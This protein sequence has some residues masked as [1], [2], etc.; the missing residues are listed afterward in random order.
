MTNVAISKS[1]SYLWQDLS[2]N[3]QIYGPIARTTRT[4]LQVRATIGST[5][6]T[7]ITFI[8]PRCPNVR[9]SGRDLIPHSNCWGSQLP[10]QK[11]WLSQHVYVDYCAQISKWHNLGAYYKRPWDSWSNRFW[12]IPAHLICRE[13]LSESNWAYILVLVKTENI[14][15]EVGRFVQSWSHI[16]IIPL[17]EMWTPWTIFHT[18]FSCSTPHSLRISYFRTREHH[19]RWTVREKSEMSVHSSNFQFG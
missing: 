4:K 1:K 15:L 14:L 13:H 17:A 10:C 11:S 5:S 18:K 2:A 9:D 8:R 16:G 3:C 12:Y 7:S 6:I 19:V